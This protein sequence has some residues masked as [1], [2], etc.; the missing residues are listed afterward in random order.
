MVADAM[1][2]FSGNESQMKR[3]PHFHCLGKFGKLVKNYG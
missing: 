2:N 1:P 3:K